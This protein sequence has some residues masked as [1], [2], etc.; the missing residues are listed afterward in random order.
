MAFKPV[1]SLKLLSVFNVKLLVNS[2]VELWTQ[3][4]NSLD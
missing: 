2:T 1:A 4:I 3:M